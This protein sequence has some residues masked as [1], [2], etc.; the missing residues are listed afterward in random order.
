MSSAAL[1]LVP[2][3][4]RH[5]DPHPAYYL[6]RP[7][8]V[9]S[10]LDAISTHQIVILQ[11]PAGYGKT[12]LL[13]ECLHGLSM[14]AVYF[15]F[16][17][18]F[19]ETLDV[20]RA[21]LYQIN[22]HI[23]PAIEAAARVYGEARGLE[24][25]L[26]AIAAAA[27]SVQEPLVVMVDDY[28][29]AEDDV[30]L[31]TVAAFLS[32][33][34]PHCHVIIS[35]RGHPDLPVARWT[36]AGR[37]A[38]YTQHELRFSSDEVRLMVSTVLKRDLQPAEVEF[39]DENVAGW[40][41]GLSLIAAVLAA[42]DDV[43]QRGRLLSEIGLIWAI[44]EYLEREV[45][46]V[47]A[48]SPAVREFL[49]QTSVLPD[50]GIDICNSFMG[51]ENSGE[52]L[53][54][55]ERRGFYITHLDDSATIYAYHPVFRRFLQKQLRERGGAAAL[56]CAYLKAARVF[57]K[58]RLWRRAVWYYLYA[59]EYGA[60]EQLIEEHS[61]EL[62]AG[63]TV[64][65]RIEYV[66]AQVVVDPV[67]DVLEQLNMLPPEMVEARPFLLI[68]KARGLLMHGNYRSAG[69][70]WSIVLELLRSELDALT[71]AQ[72]DVSGADSDAR[73]I[74]I[75]GLLHGIWP[76]NHRAPAVRAEALHNLS[77]GLEE[78]ADTLKALAVE[79][80]ALTV[81]HAIP[82]AATRLEAE[83]RILF[84]LARLY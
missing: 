13:L 42:R 62:L 81:A 70:I 80:A 39:L 7:R 79:E 53:R 74:H 82:H 8:L 20:S 23:P 15:R 14:P 12:S 63:P 55:L 68:L 28:P 44:N 32:E 17:A 76:E 9:T 43:R 22:A 29:S 30:Q 45:M 50:L 19:P 83:M 52:I 75:E 21:D 37:L 31:P 18:T 27:A 51:L 66:K 84:R 36:A 40:A 47:N 78:F 49:E 16:R 25:A 57:E 69:R 67:S 41:L 54:S 64:L 60:A 24:P 2:G 5:V 4:T 71:V 38:L 65:P 26:N 58:Y 72:D 10:L 35:T 46:Q 11:A 33:L 1:P 61:A 6:P 3:V 73:Q 34:L 48:V 56:K 59:D 77:L